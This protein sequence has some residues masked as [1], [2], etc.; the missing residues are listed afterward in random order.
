MPCLRHRSAVLAPSYASFRTAMICSSVYL[1]RAIS[2]PS[3]SYFIR[4]T[5]FALDTVFGGKVMI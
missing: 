4:R 5:L 2:P 1:F 3:M